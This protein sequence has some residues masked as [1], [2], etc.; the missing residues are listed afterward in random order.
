MEVW[1]GTSWTEV[2]DTNQARRNGGG[3]GISSADALAFGGTDV[4]ASTIYANTEIWDGTS[5]TETN[6]LATARQDVGSNGSSSQNALMYGGYSA[7]VVAATEEW[8]FAHPLKTI[9]VS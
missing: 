1:N 5:W 9:D 7:P 8:N 3:S 2:N 4:G 6:N